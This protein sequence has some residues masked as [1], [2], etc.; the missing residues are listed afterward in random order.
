MFKRVGV[1]FI[2]NLG[3]IGLKRLQ[4]REIENFVSERI[5]KICNSETP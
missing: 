2:D 4:I 3:E 1:V 5:L